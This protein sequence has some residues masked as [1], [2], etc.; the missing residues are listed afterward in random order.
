LTIVQPNLE[1]GVLTNKITSVPPLKP[2]S[3]AANQAPLARDIL[4][5]LIKNISEAAESEAASLR[6]STVSSMY[7]QIPKSMESSLLAETVHALSVVGGHDNPPARLIIGFEGVE[8]VKEKLK[9]VSE[10]LEDFFE[11]SEQVDIVRSG[12]S[13]QAD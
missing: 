3:R 5:G 1:V 8:S 6:S 7:P 13:G 4:S 12:Q 11:V 2:Y 9:T 10:E